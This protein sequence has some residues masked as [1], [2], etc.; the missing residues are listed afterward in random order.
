MSY[1]PRGFPMSVVR[2]QEA[3]QAG[4]KALHLFDAIGAP[5]SALTT[6]AN[7]LN[8]ALPEKEIARLRGI[9]AALSEDQAMTP[10]LRV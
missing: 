1:F 10:G 9:G 4:E 6:A 5:R 8:D 2:T 3:V 7:Q